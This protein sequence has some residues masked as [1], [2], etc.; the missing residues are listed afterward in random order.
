[1]LGFSSFSPTEVTYHK[2]LEYNIWSDVQILGAADKTE[3]GRKKKDTSNYTG[4]FHKPEV[5]LSLALNKISGLDAMRYNK[6][7]IIPLYNF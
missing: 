7:P 2:K 6:E 3:R 4:S 1:M 5:V